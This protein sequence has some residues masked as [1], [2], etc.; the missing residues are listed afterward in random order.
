M[1]FKKINM[2][3]GATPLSDHINIDSMYEKN[4]VVNSSYALMKDNILVLSFFKP[5]YPNAEIEEICAYHVIEHLPR[6][7]KQ[8]QKP[9]VHTALDLWNSILVGG[10]KLIL[11][12]PDFDKT[13]R[14]YLS[15]NLARKD[16]IYGLNRSPGDVHLWGYG[17]HDLRALVES[18]GFEV[19]EQGDGTDYHAKLEPC[20]RLVAI[21]R[22]N[23]NP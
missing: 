16:N 21:K 13:I 17:R 8:S 18:H 2:G 19:I 10:G 3:A 1:Q 7:G 22:E 12:C 9:N 23:R 15:G 4:F 6:P 20:Q 11:E 5:T 14:D